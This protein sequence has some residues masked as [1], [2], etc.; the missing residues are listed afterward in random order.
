MQVILNEDIKGTGKK[1][2]IVN[3]SD[4]YARNFLFKKGLAKPATSTN[5]NENK[6]AKEAKAYHK[7][8]ER[9]NYSIEAKNLNGM[10]VE[11]AVKIGE[12]GKLFGAV[13]NKEVELASVVHLLSIKSY[14]NL[15]EVAVTIGSYVTVSNG[16]S[17]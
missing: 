4:G 16:T 7:Q 1:G 3:V 15:P 5:L 13:T 11:I 17:V 8:V 6:Q 2:D 10:N 12:N 14:D 9:D